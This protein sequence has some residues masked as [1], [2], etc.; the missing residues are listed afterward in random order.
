MSRVPGG[1]V[2][3]ETAGTARTRQWSFAD[4]GGSDALHRI[5]QIPEKELI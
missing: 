1:V 4:P 5:V 2:S 3:S